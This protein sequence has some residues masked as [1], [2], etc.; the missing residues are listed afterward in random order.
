M[1]ADLEGPKK[2]TRVYLSEENC[3]Y[4]AN[5]MKKSWEKRVEGEVGSGGG[6]SRIALGPHEAIWVSRHLGFDTEWVG[7]KL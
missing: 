2:E 5:S 7:K 6:G 3:T 1:N 4:R